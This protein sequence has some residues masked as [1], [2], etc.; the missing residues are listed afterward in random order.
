MDKTKAVCIK[1]C[2]AEVKY[3]GGMYIKSNKPL[4]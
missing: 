3:V 2:E 1:Y 4:Q